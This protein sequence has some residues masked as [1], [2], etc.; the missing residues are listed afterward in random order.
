MALLAAQEESQAAEEPAPSRRRLEE[1]PVPLTMPFCSNEFINGTFNQD[2]MDFARAKKK[3]TDDAKKAAQEEADRIAAEAE[4]A[5]KEAA[6]KADSVNDA[7]TK[8]IV[9]EGAVSVEDQI[10]DAKKQV[11]L[12]RQG[13]ATD[14]EIAAA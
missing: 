2:C 10:N 6:A 1:R 5:A 11:F 7:L 3:E 8:E 14:K 4:A 12:L 9:I 13:G